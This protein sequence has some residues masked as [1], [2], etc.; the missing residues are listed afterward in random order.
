ML[1]VPRGGDQVN[2]NAERPRALGYGIN[3]ERHYT[4]PP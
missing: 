3:A 4:H 2:P 1:T